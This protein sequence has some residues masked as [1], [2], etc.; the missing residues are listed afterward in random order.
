ML[1]ARNIFLGTAKKTI[2]PPAGTGTKHRLSFLR[3][4]YFLLKI[5]DIMKNHMRFA[6]PGSLLTG[7]T[8]NHPVKKG[9]NIKRGVFCGKAASFNYP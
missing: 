5:S 1:K 9:R 7:Q 3:E 6:I 4:K 8:E 2:G